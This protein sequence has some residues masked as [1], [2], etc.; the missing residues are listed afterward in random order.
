M[1]TKLLLTVYNYSDYNPGNLLSIIKD[2]NQWSKEIKSSEICTSK[3]SV[4]VLLPWCLG[5]HEAKL[6]CNKFRGL[7]TIITSS[8]LQSKLFASLKGISEAVNC[9][10][11]RAVW[12]G[13]T[14]ERVEDHFVDANEGTEMTTLMVDTL[15]FDLTQPNGEREQNCVAAWKNDQDE[16]YWHD[17][18]CHDR[19]IPSF[20]RLDTNPRVQIRGDGANV[21][22]LSSVVKCIHYF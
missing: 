20:C 1:P 9:F 10:N 5:M 13:F 15:P 17:D 12:T 3:D 2:E 7:M 21:F 16:V 19:G 4:D 18:Y 6:L 14:D 11:S 22:D 8:E